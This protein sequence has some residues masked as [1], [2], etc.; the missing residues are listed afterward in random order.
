MKFIS[1]HFSEKGIALIFLLIIIILLVT[2]F[3]MI[4]KGIFD[5]KTIGASKAPKENYEE[6][7]GKYIEYTPEE[8]IYNTVTNNKNYTGSINNDYDFITDTSLNWRIWSIDDSKIVLISDKQISIGGYK[9]IGALHIANCTGYNNSVKILN[10]ICENCYSNSNIGAIARS[11]NI[12]DIEK[13]LDKS[14]WNPDEYKERKE[15]KK[16]LCYPSIYSI[17]TYSNIDG[18]EIEKRKY[19]RKE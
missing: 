12:E 8:G 2:I 4:L 3:S 6:L 10:Q 1:K 13:T 17:E 14:V 16:N 19:Y 9:N 15:Y 7:I 11:L 5:S 18:V